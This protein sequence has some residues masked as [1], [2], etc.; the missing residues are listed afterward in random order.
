MKA[1]V[2]GNGKNGRRKKATQKAER[3]TR[4]K[5]RDLKRDKA[6]MTER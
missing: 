3:R 4:R 6:M 5:R 2:M 1:V